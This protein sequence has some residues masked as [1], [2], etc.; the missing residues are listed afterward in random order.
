MRTVWNFSA[1]PAQ[2]PL[3]VL[4]TA[5]KELV[6]Y[7]DSGSSVMELSHRSQDFEEILAD[8]EARFR[9]LL[10]IPADYE[11][12]FLQ[13]GASLQFAMVPLN[14]KETGKAAYIDTGNWST[15]AA[16]EA[17]KTGMT[18]DII[19]SS[20]AENYAVIPEFPTDYTGYDYVHITSN[21]TIWGTEYHTYPDTGDVPLVADM[22]SD[23][24]S[25]PFDVTQFALIYAGAQKNLGIA[26]LT[27]V[28]IRKDLLNKQTALPKILNYQTHAKSDS[29]YNT[30]PTFAIYMSGLLF[31]WLEEQGGLGQ[32]AKN[33]RE[34]AE[35][36]YDYLDQ[37]DVFTA[38]IQ[39]TRYRS[40]MNIPFVTGSD[41]LD[42]AF[43][44][45][46]KDQQLKNIKGHR[47]VGGM[48]ASLYNGMPL[49]GVEALIEMMANFEKQLNE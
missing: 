36:L 2:L 14:L 6:S 7:R 15:K 29:L 22:S 41:D 32:I 49:A 1:G 45:A 3:P 20:K 43:I 12:L 38:T 39:D 25:R 10:A 13:G 17:E 23:I 11:V 4:E 46:C 24:L 35:K 5:Q 28:I 40:I 42:Q 27:F 37:S 33:N 26:G 18:V 30:P 44:A 31:Q 16:Q 19:A 21:N 8:T 48:R 34:K 9:R 47:S